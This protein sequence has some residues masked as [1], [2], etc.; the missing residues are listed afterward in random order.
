MENSREIAQKI[1]GI[2]FWSNYLTSGYLSKQYNT[3]SKRDMH[4]MLI[5][6]LF[7]IAK[8]WYL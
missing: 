6:S 1:N 5:A 7:A 3:N 2:T 4:L 8:V